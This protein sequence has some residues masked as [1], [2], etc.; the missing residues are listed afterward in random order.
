MR[1]ARYVLGRKR[2]N[3][4]RGFFPVFSVQAVIDFGAAGKPQVLLLRRA[5][6][7]AKGEWWIPGGM[8]LKTESSGKALRR[9]VKRETGLR[10]TIV[11]QLPS[12]RE[13]FRNVPGIP[14]GIADCMTENYLLR[15]PPQARIKLDAT[16]TDFR[17]AT[18]IDKD[19][20][21]YVKKHLMHSG[22]FY[23]K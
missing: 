1:L 2:F 7:P 15:P 12:A 13:V 22:L 17:M 20:H 18:A 6:E 3:Y 11:R 14:D 19:L 8:V 21:P 5:E 9:I 4:L 16:S 10:C 23:S